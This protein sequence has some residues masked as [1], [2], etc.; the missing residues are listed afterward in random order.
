MVVLEVVDR[1]LHD[2]CR[3][4]WVLDLRDSWFTCFEFRTR[5]KARSGNYVWV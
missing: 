5:L 3:Q 4:V 2:E 1:W